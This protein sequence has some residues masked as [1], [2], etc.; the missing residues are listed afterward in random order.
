M[1][2]AYVFVAALIGAACGW[3]ADGLGVWKSGVQMALAGVVSV[4]AL[5]GLPQ[6][7]AD[8]RPDL[9]AMVTRPDI[10]A[11]AWIRANT[12]INTRL[13]VNDF[14]AY[15]G[16]LIVGSDSG[17]W[18]PLLARRLTSLPPMPYGTEQSP[19]R[20]NYVEFINLQAKLVQTRGL[21]AYE[22]RNLML[23]QGVK[24][25]FIGQ[26]QGIVGNPDAP[27]LRAATL[28]GSS[29]CQLVYHRDGVYVFQL[30]R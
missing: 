16:G 11:M 13:L 27:R 15:G 30:D 21:G 25:V 14:P 12:S 19:V 10:Q 29:Y 24:Y 5:A 9:H 28:L 7:F 6:R 1:M 22:V 26:R 8:Y 20:M 2:G 17:W 4:A 3:L 18:L 23:G